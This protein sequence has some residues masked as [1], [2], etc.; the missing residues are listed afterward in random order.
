MDYKEIVKIQEGD[1]SITR[2]RIPLRKKQTRK[3]IKHT[4]KEDNLVSFFNGVDK[5]INFF[6]QMLDRIG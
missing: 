6:E 3:N 5:T 2:I 1:R 4:Q